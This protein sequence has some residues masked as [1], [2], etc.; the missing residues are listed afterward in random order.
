MPTRPEPFEP[1]GLNPESLSGVLRTGRALGL[2]VMV[3]D[4][5][6]DAADTLGVIM[7]MLGAQVRVYYD[8][9]SAFRELDTFWPHVGLFDVNMPGMD[10]VELAG[11]VRG[12]ARGRPVLLVAITGV[13]DADAL[14]RTAAVFD[15]HLSKP[16]E[17]AA[18][19]ATM[20]RF[21]DQ[22]PGALP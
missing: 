14:A 9:L 22:L 17:P 1:P 7:Q 21:K 15:L 20:R 2:R 5:N 6:R 4:D 10:G 8:G 19:Y 13:S 3:A 12:M 16:A 11:R 18:I